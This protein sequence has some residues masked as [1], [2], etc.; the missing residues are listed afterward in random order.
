M[1]FIG[2]FELGLLDNSASLREKWGLSKEPSTGS[3][4]SSGDTYKNV[5]LDRFKIK[6]RNKTSRKQ[7]GIYMMSEEKG[8]KK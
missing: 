6:N 5:D 7:I 2:L 8:I 3:G 4:C 1:G